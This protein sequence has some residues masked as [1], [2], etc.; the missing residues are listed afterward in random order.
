M[1]T[2]YLVFFLIFLVLAAVFTFLRTPIADGINTILIA[3]G[4]GRSIRIDNTDM[5]KRKTEKQVKVKGAAR[6]SAA[7]QVRIL[8]DKV[9]APPVNRLAEGKFNRKR[10]VMFIP[11]W[12]VL[13][14]FDLKVIA[15]KFNLT[16]VLAQDCMNPEA[17][18]VSF[19]M[20]PKGFQWKLIQTLS[21]DGRINLAEVFRK[22]RAPAAAWLVTEIEVDKDYPD[23]RM[24][25]GIQRFGRVFLNGKQVFV[26]TA[27]TPVRTDGSNIPVQLKK[28]RNQIIVKT[29]SSNF[30][31]WFVFLRFTTAKKV[32]LMPP[33][34]APA[35]KTAQLP[36]RTQGKQVQSPPKPTGK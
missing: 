6:I 21:N 28:G 13:G 26:S 7:A 9:S 3:I 20:I 4:E 5:V 31:S 11:Q 35:A 30:R 8:P 34:P 18:G 12:A 29:A 10:R 19:Q 22:N 32:P 23:A 36:P 33:L 24:L 14:F 16:T 1:K 27:K 2:R 17:D 15:K 25:V